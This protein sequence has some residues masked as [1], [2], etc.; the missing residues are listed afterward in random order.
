MF[1]LQRNCELENEKLVKIKEWL[2]PILM[3]KEIKYELY[4]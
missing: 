4:R 2:L 1:E 3:N